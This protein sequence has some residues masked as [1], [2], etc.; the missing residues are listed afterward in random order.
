[1]SPEV[2]A[3]RN[4]TY[5]INTSLSEETSRLLDLERHLTGKINHARPRS[6][7]MRFEGLTL[8]Q[9]EEINAGEPLLVDYGWQYWVHQITGVDYSH[10]EAMGDEELLDAFDR[11]LAMVDDYSPLLRADLSHPQYQTDP[12]A[13]LRKLKQL[14]PALVKKR[15]RRSITGHK[16]KKRQRPAPIDT[17]SSSSPAASLSPPSSESPP[18]SP[19]PLRSPE[20]RRMRRLWTQYVA[21]M[22]GQSTLL[23]RF[24][25]SFRRSETSSSPQPELASVSSPA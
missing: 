20:T 10:W 6:C 11:M 2:E 8:V 18:E 9:P 19:S 22:A 25:H 3:K 16:G 24:Q 12:R 17:A 7:N 21:S 5:V 15:A 4:V 23:E 1:M 13:L 14:I